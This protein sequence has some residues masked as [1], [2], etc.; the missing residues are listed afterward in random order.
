[1]FFSTKKGSNIVWY[2]QCLSVLSPQKTEIWCFDL[3]K[4]LDIALVI[5]AHLAF[6]FL[7]GQQ[8]G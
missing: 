5:A 8:W 1:M 3:V 4:A 2:Y 6:I 7:K